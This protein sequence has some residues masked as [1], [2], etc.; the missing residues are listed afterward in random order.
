MSFWNYLKEKRRALISYLIFGGIF[1]VS[2]LLYR[3]PLMA[4]GYPAGLCLCVGGIWLTADFIRLW[5]KNKLLAQTEA[6]TAPLPESQT[7]S[8]EQ[9]LRMIRQLRQQIRE[10]ETRSDSQR[11]EMADQYT[12]WAHQIKTPIA[13]M[14]LQLES[15]DSPMSRQLS[16]ELFR[17]SQYVEMAL[18]IQRLDA[19]DSDY[20]IRRQPLDNIIRQSVK[21][22]APEFILRR[23][24]LE[25]EPTGLEIVTDEKWL[26]FVMD[27]L[28]SNALKYT[29]SGQI[30][31]Y[32]QGTT[33]CVEDSGVG[34]AAEDLPR[35]FDK[36]YTG[37]NGRMDKN[38][39]GLGLYLCRQVC[40]RL[41]HT[42][43]AQS[44][45]GQGSRFSIDLSQKKLVVE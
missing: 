20:V 30:R 39:S 14:R 27:Q 40:G 18:V 16:S 19:E 33:L 31:I 5:R 38:A 35:I 4:V 7:V 26:G 11:R 12:L 22:F 24:R 9:Y 44:A 2:F 25:W 23:L 36:G 42:I 15:Q 21:K 10:L 45:P 29:P 41:G 32:S 8:E 17:I 13:S 34:I 6:L 28:L 37:Y 3:L 43:S 1:S